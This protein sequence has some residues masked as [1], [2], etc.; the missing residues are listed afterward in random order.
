MDDGFDRGRT[1][2]IFTKARLRG[3]GIILL[4]VVLVI[5]LSPNGAPAYAAGRATGKPKVPVAP[6]GRGAVPVKLPLS[7]QPRHGLPKGQL[8]PV[9]PPRLKVASP[10]SG[11]AAGNAARAAGSHAVRPDDGPP[12]GGTGP[13][14]TN[15]S[16]LPGL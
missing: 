12:G 13:K 9:E 8:P 7:A 1:A 5:G 3:L 15:V 4:S 2:P 6:A 14:A 10:P 11:H 16:L